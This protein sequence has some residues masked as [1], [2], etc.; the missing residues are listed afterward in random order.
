[1]PSHQFSRHVAPFAPLALALAMAPSVL[2]SLTSQPSPQRLREMEVPDNVSAVRCEDNIAD[3]KECHENYPT[4]CSASAGY[5]AF[6][7][8]LKN[9]MVPASEPTRYLTQHDYND[10]EKQTPSGLKRTNHADFKDQLAQLGE[11]QTVGLIGYLYYF[12]KTG[13]ESSNCQLTS[14]DS[15]GS[16]VDYH[17]GIGFDPNL[18]KQ[19]SA[20]PSTALKKKLQQNSVIV[21]MTPYYRFLF[22][23]SDWNLENLGGALGKQVR[24]VGQL[25]NDSEHDVASQNCSLA[26]TAAQRQKCWRYSVWEL[27]PVV[28]FQ[29]CGTDSCDE[30]S[31]SWADLGS[32]VGTLNSGPSETGVPAAG[33]GRGS[34]GKGKPTSNPS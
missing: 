22:H 23:S 19:A 33:G 31:T 15:E 16:N 28:K 13:A 6:L 32:G 7:N 25:M 18:A 1:M 30:N 14:D 4:G 11:G 24:V 17:I 27:H 3:F 29:I 8:I 2:P 21:E 10:L 12:Q 34:R 26:S 20:H 5:D 9:Q